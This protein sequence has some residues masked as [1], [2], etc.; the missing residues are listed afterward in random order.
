MSVNS[1]YRERKYNSSENDRLLRILSQPV[2]SWEK[3]WAPSTRSKSHHIHKW[4]KS[5]R[6]IVFEDEED[7]EEDEEDKDQVM[8]EADKDT[9]LA[10]SH[11]NTPMTKQQEEDLATTTKSVPLNG[12]KD[13]SAIVNTDDNT[14]GLQNSGLFTAR[15]SPPNKQVSS[16]IADEERTHTPKLSDVPDVDPDQLMADNDD[17]KE[18]NTDDLNDASRHPAFA[19]HIHPRLTDDNILGTHSQSEQTSAEGT[20]KE[21]GDFPIATT[22]ADDPFTDTANNNINDTTT[23][24]LNESDISNIETTMAAGATLPTASAAEMETRIA[25]ASPKLTPTTVASDENI[26]GNVDNSTS[27]N[28]TTQS[29]SSPTATTSTSIENEQSLLTP[30]QQ[31]QNSVEQHKGTIDIN[32]RLLDAPVKTPDVVSSTNTPGVDTPFDTDTPSDLPMQRNVN[33]VTENDTEMDMTPT[34]PQAND[35]PLQ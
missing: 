12:T 11:D 5:D 29:S 32:D 19:P 13:D 4:V 23:A 26:T 27:P 25:A 15:S 28:V 35:E 21:T 20:P 30:G 2:Q 17:D 18:S 3:K 34:D 16:T 1:R 7:D 8:T 9:P 6:T 31:P 10:T 33:V 14:S 24:E 22:M